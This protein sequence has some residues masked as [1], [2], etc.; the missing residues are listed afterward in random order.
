MGKILTKLFGKRELRVLMLGL[1]AAGKTSLDFFCNLKGV[2][3]WRE[4]GGWGFLGFSCTDQNGS[5]NLL[6]NVWHLSILVPMSLAR[7]DTKSGRIKKSWSKLWPRSILGV[8]NVFGFVGVFGILDS[9]NWLRVTNVNEVFTVILQVFCINWNLAN[10]L[11]HFQRSA[12]M[13]RLSL[14]KILNSVCGY[15][16]LRV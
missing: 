7:F 12:L 14:I 5:H 13:W 15:V 11:N 2:W 4:I 10:Q 9:P 3:R 6:E 16:I 8:P 1:D